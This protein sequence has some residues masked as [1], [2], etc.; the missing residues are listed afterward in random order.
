[1]P[2]IGFISLKLYDLFGKEIKTL[3]NEVKP[4]GT[5]EVDFDAANLKRGIYFY[6]L[7]S[8]TYSVTKKMV[9]IK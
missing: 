3:V 8:G 7:Q 5:F 1:M 9:L 2:Q 6:S 4:A